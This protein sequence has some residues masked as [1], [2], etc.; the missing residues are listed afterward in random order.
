MFQT[1]KQFPT[2]FP[3]PSGPN[4]RVQPTEVEP[5]HV[6]TDSYVDTLIA[7]IQAPQTLSSAPVPSGQIQAPPAAPVRLNILPAEQE[8]QILGDD[9]QQLVAARETARSQGDFTRA[10]EIRSEISGGA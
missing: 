5:Y 1:M 4:V 8:P 9:L 7:T 6:N 3:E 2:Q 10:D